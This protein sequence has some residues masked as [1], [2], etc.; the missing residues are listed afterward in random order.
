MNTLIATVEANYEKYEPT[1]VARLIQDFVIAKL[2]NWYVRLSRRRFWKGEYNSEKI[3][4]YQTLYECMEKTAILA[5]PIAPFFMDRLFEDLNAISRNYSVSSI[6]LAPFPKADR[7]K[8]DSQLEQ[9]MRLA[10]K[11]RL[12]SPS[13]LKIAVFGLVLSKVCCKTS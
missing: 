7:K 9:K 4:A 1:K 13:P 6:H 11:R 2:S 12:Y 3:S 8:I 10:Q 5:A